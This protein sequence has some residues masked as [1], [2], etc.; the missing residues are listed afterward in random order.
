L[1]LSDGSQKVALQNS[2]SVPVAPDEDNFANPP[3]AANTA[4]SDPK[5]D[6]F[7]TTPGV[8]KALQFRDELLV[9][10][11]VDLVNVTSSFSTPIVPFRSSAL[12]SL[13][14]DSPFQEEDPTDGTAREDPS[15]LEDT[16]D[17]PAE[18]HGGGLEITG[19]A[20]DRT[21]SAK[22]PTSQPRSMPLPGSDPSTPVASTKQL[23][24]SS[25]TENL[26]HTHSARKIRVTSDVER[27]VVCHDK[28]LLVLSSL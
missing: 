12:R 7:W 22:H 14:T 6:S 18:V 2:L 19:Q 26:G 27:I 28:K 4:A 17:R 9:N 24:S 20:I 5:E 8:G 13:P 21:N 10:E 11:D 1:F 23:T 16:F 15:T 3:E 25:T